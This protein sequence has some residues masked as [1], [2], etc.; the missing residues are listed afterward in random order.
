MLRRETYL[1]PVLDSTSNGLMCLHCSVIESA[2][3]ESSYGLE[4]RSHDTYGAA[5]RESQTRGFQVL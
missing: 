5:S 3:G 4:T 1:V 2:L